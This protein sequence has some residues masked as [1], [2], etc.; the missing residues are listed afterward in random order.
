MRGLHWNIWRSITNRIAAF[1]CDIISF[2]QLQLTWETFLF[3]WMYKMK[4]Y[5]DNSAS[6]N[7]TFILF[8]VL[9][10]K[11]VS[12]VC[13]ID[14]VLVK[15]ANIFVY[16]VCLFLFN[17]FVYYVYCW[18][19][20]CIPEPASVCLNKL[21]LPRRA[22]QI[23]TRVIPSNLPIFCCMIFCIAKPEHKESLQSRY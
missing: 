23:Y 7:R 12:N 17:I 22:I 9:H 2:G 8:L 14:T 10:H 16:Y 15:N 5:Y 20:K 19:I 1:L 11:I 13:F 6:Q 4:I 18:L 21:N 3:P